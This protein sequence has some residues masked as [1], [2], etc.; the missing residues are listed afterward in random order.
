[1]TQDFLD[2][3][4]ARDW[5]ADPVSHN[6]TRPEQLDLMLSILA[7]AYQSGDTILDLGFGTGLVE[8]MIFERIPGAHVIGVDSSPAMMAIA[9]R[10]L[11]PF[12]EQYRAI[13][14][15]LAELD[16][17][18]LEPCRFIIS[19]QA[20]H[21]LTDAQMQVAYRRIADLMEPDGIFLL[22]DRI[23]ADPPELF[24]LYRSVLRWQDQHYGAQSASAEGE[25]YETHAE[26]TRSGGDLPLSLPR[27]LE[28][29]RSAGLNVACLHL[30]GLRAL[31]A[32]K[33]A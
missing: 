16:T 29:M 7:D 28:L 20:L 11:Q 25:D 23:A 27:H 19:I 24:D 5:D 18:S 10:R 21:H 2:P 12:G 4:G 22:L 26:R 9:H 3:N 33:K 1:M 6:P 15:D 30:V 31:I 13:Q 14:H 32:A 17:L 8:V